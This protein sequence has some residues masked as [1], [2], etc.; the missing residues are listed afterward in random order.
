MVYL[1]P[2]TPRPQPVKS[3]ARPSSIT[4]VQAYASDQHGAGVDAAE[5]V[6]AS[7]PG[8]LERR[9][10]DRRSKSSDTMLETRAGDRRKARHAPINISI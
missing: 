2:I 10:Q 7:P 9:K 4:P 5:E 1:G 3:P 8:G 6:A